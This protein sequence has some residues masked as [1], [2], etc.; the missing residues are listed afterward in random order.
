ML[1]EHQSRQQQLGLIGEKLAGFKAR[2][3]IG[4]VS[5]LT[6]QLT[7]KESEGFLAQVKE[8]V[9]LCL[10]RLETDIAKQLVLEFYIPTA[11]RVLLQ[12]EAIAAIVPMFAHLRHDTQSE[13]RERF[14]YLINCAVETFHLD[15]EDLRNAKIQAEETPEYFMVAAYGRNE[16][17]EPG[18]AEIS[19]Q[20]CQLEKKLASGDTP[21]ALDMARS[22]AADLSQEEILKLA[23]TVKD[24]TKTLLCGNDPGLACDFVEAFMLAKVHRIALMDDVIDAIVRLMINDKPQD[25]KA[26]YALRDTFY[27]TSVEM[28]K[29]RGIFSQVRNAEHYAR[30]AEDI[31]KIDKQTHEAARRVHNSITDNGSREHTQESLTPES[32]RKL[33]AILRA[34]DDENTILPDEVYKPN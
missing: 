34:L 18:I 24:Y 30:S 4:L 26:I 32:E 31:V 9:R 19:S 3:A 15:D 33:R 20:F 27:L 23:P 13:S 10:S 5:D 22:L 7:T 25:A 17:E 2:D 21:G 11:D 12:P 16:K 1:K 14:N 6:Y 8:N 28:R 29:A